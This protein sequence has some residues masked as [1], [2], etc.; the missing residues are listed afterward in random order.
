MEYEGQHMVS[1]ETNANLTRATFDIA[2]FDV[3][4]VLKQS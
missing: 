1:A 3:P 2:L 4:A